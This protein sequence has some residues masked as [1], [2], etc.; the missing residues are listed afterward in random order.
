MGNVVQCLNNDATGPYDLQ[1]QVLSATGIP[2]NKED[3]K[4]RVELSGQIETSTDGVHKVGPCSHQSVHPPEQPPPSRDHSGLFAHTTFFL[5]SYQMKK[6]RKV[7]LPSHFK[8]IEAPCVPLASF[9]SLL[10]N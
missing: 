5:G 3:V 4:V 9:L 7:H 8:T 6:L 10:P 2:E 1:I